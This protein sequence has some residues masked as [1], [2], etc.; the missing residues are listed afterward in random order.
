MWSSERGTE[1]GIFRKGWYEVGE[2][3]NESG[4]E[5]ERGSLV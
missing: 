5:E 4:K 1:G 2:G 3:Q